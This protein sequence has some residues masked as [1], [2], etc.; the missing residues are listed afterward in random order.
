MDD[1]VDPATGAL[2]VFRER[3]ALAVA[4]CRGFRYSGI[5][6]PAVTF[7]QETSR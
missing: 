7:D 6:C 2:T 4:E 1:A 5:V 3:F